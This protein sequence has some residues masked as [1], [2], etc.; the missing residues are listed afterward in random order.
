MDSLR[1]TPLRE[2]LAL[3]GELTVYSRGGALVEEGRVCNVVGVVKSGY[4]KY[5]G[6]DSRGEECVTGFS[7]CG[8]IVTDYVRSFLHNRPALTSII[9][10]CDSEVLQLPFAIARPHMLQSDPDFVS[11]TSS[12]LLEEAYKRY[13]AMHRL[14]PAERYAELRRRMPPDMEQLPLGEL[15]SFLGISRRQFQRIRSEF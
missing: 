4:F 6:F 8:E 11:H 9:A 1:M 7:F 10:G 3:H 14:S 15:A 13:L 2:Y 5:T 12:V